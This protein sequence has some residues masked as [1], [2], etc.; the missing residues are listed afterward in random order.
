MK[1]IFIKGVVLSVAGMLLLGGCSLK[2]DEAAVHELRAGQEEAVERRTSEQEISEREIS[3]QEI[4]GWKISEQEISEQESFEQEISEQEISE[5]ETSEQESA[6]QE[7]SGLAENGIPTIKIIQETREWYSD[8]GAELL[9]ETKASRVEVIS[10]GFDALRTTLAGQW[11]G[12]DDS[13][14]EYLD[15]AKEI[16]ASGDWDYPTW[17]NTK[18][19][20]ICRL[21]NHVVS[22]N[23]YFGDYLGGS[24]G[25]HGSIGRTYDV[26]SGKELQLEDIL[27]DSQGFYD[28]AVEYIIARLGEEVYK[29]NLYQNYAE[30]VRTDTFGETSA[31]WYLDS[32]G[33]VITYQL[34]QIA[35]YV[36]GT[37]SV[38]LP[39]DEFA[40]YIKEDY[41]M[42][43]DSFVT[44]IE[45]NED[46]SGLI[47][48][49][50]EVMLV[51]HYNGR[52][53]P[54]DDVSVVSGNA[55]ETVGIFDRVMWKPYVIKRAD[56]RSFLI[57]SCDYATDVYD[58]YVTYVYEVTGGAVRFCDKMDGV[59]V[60]GDTCAGTDR[61]G[62]S[63]EPLEDYENRTVYQL[64]EDG[65]LVQDVSEPESTQQTSGQTTKEQK[66]A[67]MADDKVPTIKITRDR[68]KWYSDD[69]KVLL[70]TAE[71]GRVEVVSEGFA[72][73]R[74]ALAGQW[75]GLG[76]YGQEELEW[77]RE[78]YG[79]TERGNF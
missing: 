39:Y 30:T 61:I 72:A 11:R 55:S 19:A 12:L 23:D 63:V 68:K 65:K 48:E 15:L 54:V 46:I 6:E 10:E 66:F 4:S 3:E 16:Y 53:N 40:A 37:P 44:D 32:K 73:L 51:V 70:L 13:I 1:K 17:G 34:Y 21:D 28:K 7:S 25:T 56:G 38:T 60:V 31:S 78:R 35:P 64:T 79:M 20:K 22:L 67:K 50:G 59:R 77:A 76:D 41:R 36:A 62:L 9:Y 45:E 14:P 5:Q 57:F 33:I 2:S 26:R 43:C 49:T 24:H 29:K 27:T 8:D 58:D 18:F 69:G 74:A 52:E 75:K 47:G 42:S 71:A